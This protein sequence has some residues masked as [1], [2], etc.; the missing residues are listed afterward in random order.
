MKKLFTLTL[1]CGLWACKKDDKTPQPL[2]GGSLQITV[3]DAT[4]W[5]AAYPKGE[6]TQQATVQL[7]ASR[8][9][10]LA[11]K[12]AFTATTNQIGVA[13]FKQVPAG[14]YFI[15]A[16][17]EDKSNTWDDGHGRTLVSD[18]IFQTEA[19]I[20]APQTPIQQNAMTGDF[21]FQDLNGDGII[22]DNDAAEAPF[23]S[24]TAA[25]DSTI[26]KDIIIG[27]K[28]NS[29][30]ALY[31]TYQEVDAFLP[32]VISGV[33]YLHRDLAMLDGVLSDDADCS[34]LPDWCQY[35][36][37]TFTASSANIWAIWENYFGNIRRLNL[38]LASLQHIGGENTGLIAQIKAARAFLYLDMSTY[39]GGLPLLE[40]ATMPGDISRASLEATR[41]FIK[42][43]LNDALPSLP[44]APPANKKMELT[45]GA[46]NMMLARLALLEKNPTAIVSYTN[47]VISSGKYTLADSAQIFVSPSN[48]E[49][50]WNQEQ[51]SGMISPFKEYFVRGGL[52]VNFLPVIRYTETYL[53]NAL[54]YTMLNDLDHAT[55]AI[56]KVRTRGKKP[57]ISFA[58]IEDARKEVDALF[59]EELYREGFRFRYLVAT[60]Q[61][62]QVLS[63]K[64][65]HEY[66]ALLPIYQDKLRFYPNLYQNPGY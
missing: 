62:M 40:T 27:Y 63:T 7:F 50:I 24:A 3:Y 31:K 47:K 52:T 19:E 14:S 15:V 6:R 16:F 48:P 22:N 32:N 4:L 45:T 51:P 34:S 53:L 29:Q 11:K 28:S 17:K 30:A 41:A 21:R 42:K 33:S 18:S 12:T 61:A 8:A 36:Q 37:F 9:D 54:A 2:P 39:F 10:Y 25:V 60:G 64:G 44:D 59:K 55:A 35:D 13:E 20:K 38:M 26:S 1:L 66:N 23:S 65:Y 43:D 46:A 57:A 58:T 49:I 5:N 56:N